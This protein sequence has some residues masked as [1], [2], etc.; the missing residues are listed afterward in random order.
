[1][2]E[3]NDSEKT[4]P[5]SERKLEKAKEDGS[6]LKAPDLMFLIVAL[7][8]ALSVW[9]IAA[10]L[11]EAWMQLWDWRALW[12]RESGLNMERIGASF[13]KC[14]GLVVGAS[15]LAVF[16]SS[17]AA[18]ALGGFVIS[19]KAVSLDLSRLDPMKKLGQMFSFSSGQIIWPMA[20]GFLA[21]AVSG[22][23]LS[24][25]IAALVE[26]DPPM[27]AGVKAMMPLMVAFTLFALLDF[28]IQ[29]YKRNKQLGMT[30]Q[31]VKDEN[32]ESEGDPHLKAKIR[33]M[34][35]ARSKSRMM[36]AVAMADVVVVNP[37]HYLVAMRWDPSQGGAP[38]VVAK[39]LDEL[40]LAL[41]KMAIQKGIPVLE[42]PP[43][44]RALW[45]ASKMDRPIP[46]AYFEPVAMLLAWA[47]SI[48]DGKKAVEPSLEVPADV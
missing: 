10:P 17:M 19:A 48:K 14:M 36:S 40:A 7:L 2:S 1:M 46:L 47:Y 38:I 22:W 27:W 25:F 8:M 45:K 31:E 16:S 12:T 39:G 29:W 4:L 33:S 9:A 24:N 20:K 6:T 41:K 15:C 18:W 42:S 43:F 34:A 5:P 37:E 28:F 26:R 11:K 21:L 3:E 30:L 32:K 44:A 23:G 13:G 35:R